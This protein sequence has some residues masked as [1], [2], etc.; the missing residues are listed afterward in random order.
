MK[1]IGSIA[2]HHTSQE[3]PPTGTRKPP[4]SSGSGAPQ[5]DERGELE[6]PTS[7]E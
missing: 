6:R 3:T 2:S 7:A 1:R 5:L 4:R